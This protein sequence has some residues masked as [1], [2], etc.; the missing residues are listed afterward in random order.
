[1]TIRRSLLFPACIALSVASM[2]QCPQLFD[3]QGNPSDA[4]VWI[5]CSG[6]N[7]TLLVA[8]S[9]ATGAYTIDWGDGSAV[10]SGAGLAPP[11]TVSH[12][13]AAAVAVY[14]VN[15][16]DIASGCVVTGTVTM[17]QST[18][19][20]IQ[21][22]VGGLTQVCAPQ[23]VDFINSSTN[24]SPNTVF[25]W[26]FGDGTTWVT[27]DY[28]N[29]G[30]VLSHTYLPGTVGCETTVR[31]SAE[32]ACN[33]LQG[34]P[35]I[36]TFNPIRVWDIDTANISPSATLLCWPDNEVTYLNTTNRN[37]L[38][39]GNIFQRYESWNFGD[40]WGAGHDSI[41]D[42]TPWPPTFPHTIAYPAIGTY[43]VMMLDSN[44][45][46]IDTA[47]VTINIVPPPSVT[48]TANPTPVCA[49]HPVHFNETTIGGANYFQWDF[50][51]GNGFNW[52]SAGDQDHTFN[53]QGTY[54][55]RY[56][57]SIQGA[58][59][60]CADTA[61][62]TVTVLPS[63]TA[64]FTLDE[65]AA[66]TSLTT[67]PTNT[68]INAANYLWDFGDG[69]T[70]TQ[71]DPPP[72]T[73][74]TEGDYVITLTASNNQGC[75]N[76]A[77]DTVH[78]YGVPQP[79]I[80]A[81]NVCEGAPAQFA[82]LTV[83]APGNPV[84]Q[85]LWDFGDGST[86]TVQAPEHLYAGGATYTVT[87]TVTTPYCS[88]TGTSTITVEPKPVA[89]ISADPLS[90]CS[91]MDVTFTNASTG[92]TNYVWYFGDGGN[93]NASDPVHTYLN[94]GTVDSVYTARLVAS[95]ASGCSDTVNTVIT[96]APTVLS[97]FT[98]D[99]LPGCA[100]LDVNFTNNSTGATNFQW[101]FGDGT[102]STVNS[103]S[104]TYVNQ[105]GVL[106]VLTVTLAVSNW[107]GCSST[108]Q[109]SITVYPAPNFTF[110]AQPDSG[111][112]PLLVVFPSV[113]GAVS[114]Q[115]NFG[116]GSTGGGPTPQHTYINSTDSMLH[117]NVSLVATN[118]F[119]CVDST[120]GVIVVYPSPVAAFTI[121][122]TSGCH[123]LTTTLTN[124]S[125][126][127]SAYHW[128]YGDGQT[129]DT[130][131]SVHG[132]SWYNYQGPG[133]SSNPVSLTAIS[134][135]G[136]TNTATATVQVFPQ[137]HAAFVADSA[138][139][140]PL[141]P[142]FVNLSTGAGSYLWTFGDG[143]GS[144]STNPAHL[145]SQS[146]LADTLFHP[147]LIAN[148]S[149]G[150]SDTA[151]TT[152]LVHPA[153]I[154]QFTAAPATGCAPVTINFQDLTIGAASMIWQFGDGTFQNAMPG[155]ISHDY[156]NNGTGLVQYPV[157][158]TA[159]SPFGCTDTCTVPVTVYPAI[160]ALFQ[161]PAEA[162]SPAVVNL[163]DES[164]GTTQALWNMGDGVTLVGTDITHTYVNP[165]TTDITY[166][167]TLTATSA[168]GCT[169]T[170]QHDIVIHPAPSASFIATPFS[171][172]F[173]DATVTFNNTTPNGQW[174]YSWSMGDG[175]N[176]TAEDPA[177]YTYSTWGTYT[178]L[179][180][181]STG[182]C[183]DTASQQVTIVPPL[184]TA[185][186]IGSGEGCAPLTISFMNTSLLAQGYQWQ[187]GDGATSIAE[188]PVHEY[189]TPGTYTVSLTAFGMNGGT[190]TMV[191]L[192]SVIVHPSAMAF[193]TLQ[194]AEVVAPTQPLF[195]YNL[196]TNSSSYVWDFGDGSFSNDAAPVHYYQTPGVFDIS[197]IANNVWNCPDTFSI[198]GAVTAIA[199]G[200]ITFPNA[201]T[202][203]NNGPTDG[204]YDPN[205]FD[206]DIFHPLSKGVQEYKLQV[207]NRWGELLFETADINTGWDGYYRGHLSKQDVYVW[208]A[209]AKFVTGDEKRM[210]GDLTLLR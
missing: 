163:T 42:W 135:E 30:Q 118:A 4:P 127:A 201:F 162:C 195:T 131:A 210:T 93:S 39:Q 45:C 7:F 188:N 159:T 160:E 2:A 140:S 192:D 74:P 83:T 148:S 180:T 15:F 158:L 44:Y 114:Y 20:S 199:G 109:Q 105:T 146:G 145:Y 103:P 153:P 169:R 38:T 76:T 71:P 98:H 58:T 207:F 167:V 143:G 104:H 31:L 172:V 196:S 68:S 193:F 70:D 108:S 41:I 27:Y 97:M 53:T 13:Y 174:G 138:G 78:V 161:L 47:Y 171:Q 106:Q 116:D 126:G 16:T 128:S 120:S 150:C 147:V 166:T 94:P 151:T 9:T 173:P 205:S 72:H 190:S 119:G 144:A 21:I 186:F 60:G 18:S 34:G 175:S 133:A 181:V 156:V 176:S 62:A 183:T 46:G 124:T 77:T 63:P 54:D 49:G 179:L 36:A 117:F 67:D 50:D 87:L 113:I 157:H 69:T 79:V 129:S 177:A 165:G 182:M 149:F 110:S 3:S 51:D 112:T 155:N 11:Q 168:Y 29:L 203:G 185:S 52:T 73:Y 80:G 19:A 136:C 198:P 189:Y 8:S 123:P 187:F 100:P 81:Q 17:E 107:A 141:N 23:N 43:E 40:Y 90:G 139:C 22:P 82:D 14:T 91:P 142:H 5:S 208:K 56:A 26:N 194:P 59:A 125:Q 200:E 137:V 152:V 115:W 206:N 178:V 130:L 170:L 25:Q 204:V 202:P 12:V 85:W 99:A 111:C 65:H 132:H 24:T 66:C 121:A 86:D 57:A 154:A 6:G 48:L 84:Q 95:T 61:M 33:T 134:D 32:N 102:T 10:Q 96:V 184:P 28:T 55:V 88:G 197:L 209:Y 37:C 101:D 191:K 92:A 75:D 164:T 64:Q 122:S 35:S 1:M 89:A